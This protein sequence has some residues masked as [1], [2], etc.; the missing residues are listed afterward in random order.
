MGWK[1]AFAQWSVGIVVGLTFIAVVDNE[2]IALT[3]AGAVF[4]ALTLVLVLGRRNLGTYMSASCE[5]QTDS[6][7]SVLAGV[8]VRALRAQRGLRDVHHDPETGLIQGAWDRMMRP[9][10]ALRVEIAQEGTGSSYRVTSSEMITWIATDFGDN[11]RRCRKAA[12]TIE[13]FLGHQAR[14]SG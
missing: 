5:T 11:K 4:G 7:P 6:A 3:V 8:A 2:S 14:R 1:S 12:A 10:T 9:P 13:R